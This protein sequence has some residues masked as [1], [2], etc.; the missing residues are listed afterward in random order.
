MSRSRQ[1]LSR[2]RRRLLTRRAG[3]LQIDQHIV[4]FNLDRI[5]PQVLGRGGAQCLAGADVE[6]R[7]VQGAF[8]RAVLHPAVGEQALR[9]RAHALGREHLLADAVERDR[10]AIDF[11]PDHVAIAERLETR[12]LLPR[13]AGSVLSGPHVRTDRELT[14]RW[15]AGNAYRALPRAA[16]HSTSLTIPRPFRARGNPP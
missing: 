12:H 13:H 10:L 15:H 2:R 14:P 3:A 5:S 9:M 4:G 11:D 1:R 6:A 7:L 16:A 8:D